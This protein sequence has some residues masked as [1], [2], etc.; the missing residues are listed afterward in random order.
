MAK[1]T[2]RRQLRTALNTIA[3]DYKVAPC[4][5]DGNKQDVSNMAAAIM[6]AESL[7]MNM[8]FAFLVLGMCG[9][10]TPQTALCAPE[11]S[12]TLFHEMFLC[13][14]PRL[15]AGSPVQC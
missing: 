15:A 7:H 12:C 11:S 5:K 1:E 3:R 2:E 8:D 13:F 10:T 9:E 6:R 4:D 14:S